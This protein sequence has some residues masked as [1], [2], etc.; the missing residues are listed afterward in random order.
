ME[1]FFYKNPYGKSE[2]MVFLESLDFATQTKV[3]YTLKLLEEYGNSLGMPTSR[4]LGGGLFELR[5]ASIRLFYCFSYGK[6]LILSG[7]VKKTQKTPKS[8]IVN[9]MKKKNEWLTR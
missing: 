5:A 7:F 1:V 4:A 2:V 9:A 8:E 3:L 6:A